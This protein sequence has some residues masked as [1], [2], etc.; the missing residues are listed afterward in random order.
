[1]V[2][3]APV[4][5]STVIL[6]RD[7]DPPGT[8]WQCYMVRRHVAS[9]F[10]ADVFVFPG[11]KV[12]PGDR[13][14]GLAPYCA[15]RPPLESDGG[16]E[17][18]RSLRLAATRELFEEAGVL[19]AHRR[20]EQTLA[21]IGEDTTHFADHRRRLQAGE[22]SL[23]EL[24][25]DENLLYD[26][27]RLHGISRWVTP[28]T[29]PRRFDTW[30]FVARVP[31]GQHPVHDGGETTDGTWIDPPSALASHRQ[32]DFPLVFATEKHLEH[33]GTFQS[34][35]SLIASAEGARLHPVMPRM[36]ESNGETRF[37]LPGDQGY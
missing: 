9:D 6:V 23:L 28:E 16:L 8:P 20:G 1:M 19:L 13:A 5:A 24:A 30:F 34:I 15:G 4:D 22:E 36:V 25:H 14:P 11:G 27:D 29:L 37:L 17:D 18:W 31:D 2:P 35:E 26:L 3:V 33:L 21:L 12:D 32:G 10:A 7:G